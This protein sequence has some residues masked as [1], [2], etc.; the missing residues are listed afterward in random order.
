MAPRFTCDILHTTGEMKCAIQPLFHPKMPPL[1]FPRA[2]KPLTVLRT[3]SHCLHKGCPGV[4]CFSFRHSLPSLLE[5]LFF[6]SQIHGHP[7][8]QHDSPAQVR[9][10]IK[11]NARPVPCCQHCGQLVLSPKA[12][13]AIQ[14][15]FVL[16]HVADAAVGD[17]P[18]PRS[19]QP[20]YQQRRTL[21]SLA[22]SA[23]LRRQTH[24][25]FKPSRSAGDSVH[26]PLRSL[27]Y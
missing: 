8:D 26:G 17:K 13:S 4:Q 2:Y 6:L 16:L 9:M 18:S 10:S 19:P 14:K 21:L 22:A 7:A 23:A 15:R 5:N 1:P 3:A 24:A 12:H 11:H 20:T 25:L 27:L